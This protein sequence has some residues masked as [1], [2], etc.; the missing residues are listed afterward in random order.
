MSERCTKG[1]SLLT[2]IVPGDTTGMITV[3]N[4]FIIYAIKRKFVNVLLYKMKDLILNNYIIKWKVVN[5]Y[6][7]NNWLI[8]KQIQQYGASWFLHCNCFLVCNLQA[9]I[10]PMWI[11]FNNINHYFISIYFEKWLAGSFFLKW[12][13]SWGIISSIN[14]KFIEETFLFINIFY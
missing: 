10:I 6:Y 3:S 4:I 11:F 5:I 7:H 14:L 9:S 13:D 12:D 1:T 8:Y 2:R